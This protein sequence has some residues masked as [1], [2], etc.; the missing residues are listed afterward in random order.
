MKVL[1]QVTFTEE[2]L[3]GKYHLLCSD[4]LVYAYIHSG[5]IPGINNRINFKKMKIQQ[6]HTIPFK[7]RFAHT[8]K[9]YLAR[10]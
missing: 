6:K 8:R 4:F 7:N 2:I 5:N 3:H 1:H 9:T 10:F